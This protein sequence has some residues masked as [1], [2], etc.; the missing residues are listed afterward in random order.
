MDS[1][2]LISVF[3]LYPGLKMSFKHNSVREN[4]FLYACFCWDTGLSLREMDQNLEFGGLVGYG[5]SCLDSVFRYRLHAILNDA[6]GAV[7]ARS[8]K[9]LGYCYMIWRVQIHVCLVT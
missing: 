3:R 9:G 4:L 5:S 6:A 2:F 8:G 7:P 1:L